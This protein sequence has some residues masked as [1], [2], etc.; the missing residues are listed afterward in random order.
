M[1]SVSYSSIE[2][3]IRRH[4]FSKNHITDAKINDL[5]QH[6]GWTGTGSQDNPII[7][8][9]V[10][11]LKP[12]IWVH[13]STLHY[14]IRNV[15]IYKLMIE[16]TQHILIENCKLE[17]LEIEESHTVHV[18]NNEIDDLKVAFSK[19]CTFE[20]NRIT[21]IALERLRS[22]FFDQLMPS[23]IRFLELVIVIF[24]SVA[25]ILFTLQTTLYF[26]VSPAML[27]LCVVIGLLVYKWERQK[28]RTKD[29]PENTLT[30]N[31]VL[32]NDTALYHQILEHY[33]Y[34]SSN[35]FK[36]NIPV[37]IVVIGGVIIAFMILYFLGIFPFK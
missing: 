3:K 7:I 23:I 5:I 15:I 20:N 33:Q 30:N 6:M 22:K 12:N 2:R 16:N 19:G 11:G 14:I 9:N 37:F 27:L 31:Q 25:S 17:R 18:K 28:K 4:Q 24:L 1:E 10:D 13:K 29:M 26:V 34:L 36:Y 8:D 32:I 35:W 21:G